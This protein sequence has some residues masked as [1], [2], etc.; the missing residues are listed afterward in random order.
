MRLYAPASLRVS[1]YE[2]GSNNLSETMPDARY[3]SS[4]A[5]TTIANNTTRMGRSNRKRQ[6]IYTAADN[7]VGTLGCRF[8]KAE[9]HRISFDRNTFQMIRASRARGKP[10]APTRS[11][12]MDAE[13]GC[14]K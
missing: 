2:S 7:R 14:R 5:Q 3:I 6:D 13:V 11:D 9:Q 4:P 12:P 1:M 10:S 8:L